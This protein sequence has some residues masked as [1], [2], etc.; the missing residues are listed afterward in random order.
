MVT[1]NDTRENFI[2]P[3][4]AAPDAQRGARRHAGFTLIELLVVIAII[5]LLAAILFPVFQSAREKARQISCISNERQIGL[6]ILQYTQ[7]YDEH[8]PNGVNPANLWFWSGEGWAG[9]CSAY[10]KS[11]ALLRCPDDSTGANA[12]NNFP[13]SYGYNINMVSLSGA[14]GADPAQAG[15]FNTTPPAGLGLSDLNAPAKSVILFEVS[16]V[17]S[18]VADPCEGAESGGRMGQYLSASGN[19]L[20]NRLYAHLD[21][22]TGTDNHYATGFLG[23]RATSAGGQFDPAVGRHGGGSNYLLADGHVRW[24]QGAQISSGLAAA[25]PSDPQGATADGFSAAGTEAAPT[26]FA[27]TFSPR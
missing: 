12:P 26:P 7:D 11:A 14:Y 27:A 13:V 23:G 25:S 16:G 22:V 15:Q 9:Q 2:S 5:S 6:A 4:G 18:N 21:N 10:L 3:S 20:D 24:S 8:L 17:T 19:G 1:V